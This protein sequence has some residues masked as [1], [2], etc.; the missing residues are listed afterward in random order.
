MAVQHQRE[1]ICRGFSNMH[2]LLLDFG[3]RSCAHVGAAECLG[4]PTNVPL[5]FTLNLLYLGSEQ[6]RLIWWYAAATG[7][8]IGEGQLWF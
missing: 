5:L 8:V 2:V 3:V 6:R 4:Q 1:A 7:I